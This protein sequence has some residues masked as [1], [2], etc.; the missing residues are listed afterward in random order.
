M[1]AQRCTD[2]SHKGQ[3]RERMRKGIQIICI[4]GGE[5]KSAVILIVNLTALFASFSTAGLLYRSRL[6]TADTK[7]KLRSRLRKNVALRTL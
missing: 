4:N 5:A 7:A 6:H 1:N 3:K 2:H